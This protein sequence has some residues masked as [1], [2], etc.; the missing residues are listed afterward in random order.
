MRDEARINSELKNYLNNG[1]F[2]KMGLNGMLPVHNGK[3]LS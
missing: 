2:I 3:P 1:E